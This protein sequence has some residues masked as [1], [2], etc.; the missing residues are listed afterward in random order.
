[1]MN[2]FT[3]V[4]EIQQCFPSD[5]FAGIVTGI[6]SLAIGGTLLLR[7]KHDRASKVFPLMA[8]IIGSI[9]FLVSLII[10]G[11]SVASKNKLMSA[12]QSGQFQVVEGLV[13]VLHRQPHSGHTKGDV[14]S[15]NGKQF[16]INY[17]NRTPAYSRTISHGGV[18]REGTYARVYYRNGDI[19][20]IDIRNLTNEKETNTD[21]NNP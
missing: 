13:D 21:V 8:V 16:E 12:Y 11:G 7:K 9:L 1:M 20:R 2:N 4:Y 5:L 3:T 14:I 10:F 19:L 6:V 17:F 18:L 15:I